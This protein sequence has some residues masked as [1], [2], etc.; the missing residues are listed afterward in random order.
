MKTLFKIGLSS[1]SSYKYNSSEMNCFLKYAEENYEIPYKAF[2]DGIN[3]TGEKLLV[4]LQENCGV[5][6]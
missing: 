5:K 2:A 3:T 1:T 4:L 6:F